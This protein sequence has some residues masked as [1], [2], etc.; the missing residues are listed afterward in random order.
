MY[1]RLLF[2]YALFV[3]ALTFMYVSILPAEV[4]L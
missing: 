2:L 1:Y 3:V 4:L